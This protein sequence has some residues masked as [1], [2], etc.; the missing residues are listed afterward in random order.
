MIW[1]GQ[2]LG[3]RLLRRRRK[4]TV[5]SSKR[6]TFETPRS[7]ASNASCCSRREGDGYVLQLARELKGDLVLGGTA[8]RSPT[9]RRSE[10]DLG[11]RRSRRS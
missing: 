7:P 9:S 11:A 4:V 6:A 8:T 10:V 3:Y 2:I 1:R 5:G